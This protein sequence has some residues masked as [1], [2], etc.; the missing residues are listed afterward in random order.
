MALALLSNISDGLD[1]PLDNNDKQSLSTTKLN[2]F[3]SH[4]KILSPLRQI[5]RRLFNGDKLRH[6]RLLGG[7][8]REEKL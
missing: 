6:K 4:N 1:N 3:C 8:G 5:R 7:G 2:S